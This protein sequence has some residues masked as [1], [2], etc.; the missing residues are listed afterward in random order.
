M[1]EEEQE[2]E[3]GGVNHVLERLRF[4]CEAAQVHQSLLN[5]RETPSVPKIVAW[6]DGEMHFL[7]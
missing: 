5:D 7:L 4:Y 3:G 1:E 2:E 6:T